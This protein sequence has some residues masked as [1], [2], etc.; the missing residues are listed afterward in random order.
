LRLKPDYSR[1]HNNLGNVLKQT[2]EINLAIEHY[3]KALASGES[4]VFF[5][6]YYNLGHAH[7]LNRDYEA[8]MQYYMKSIEMDNRFTP[9][10]YNIAELY[11]QSG[12]FELARSHYV[13]AVDLKPTL[14]DS[15]DRI[16]IVYTK[17]KDMENAIV[18]F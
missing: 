14:A 8:A 18:F 15:Y 6:Y 16:G 5:L 12:Q 10:H 7:T 2:G 1:A 11:E 17:E 3:N 9:A 4:D 13:R